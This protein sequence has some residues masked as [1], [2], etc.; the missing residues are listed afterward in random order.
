M[1]NSKNMSFVSNFFIEELAHCKKCCEAIGLEAVFDENATDVCGKKLKG[2][3]AMYVN[4]SDRGPK[5]DSFFEYYKEVAE[6]Y[7]QILLDEGKITEAF[8]KNHFCYL[9]IEKLYDFNS[10]KD[11]RIV[12]NDFRNLLTHGDP[13]KIEEYAA[14]LE[15][16]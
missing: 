1:I 3:F 14:M 2:S 7:K 13:D 4:K 8:A 12:P 11:D 15:A 16:E 10:Y 9:G 5:I 6:T